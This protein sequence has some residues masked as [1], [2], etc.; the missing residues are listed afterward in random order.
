MLCN[1]VSKWL[2]TEVQHHM[3]TRFQEVN[4]KERVETERNPCVKE[5]GTSCWLLFLCASLPFGLT[6]WSFW[7]E[8][9][10]VPLCFLVFSVFFSLLIIHYLM[11]SSC[12]L[13]YNR[14]RKKDYSE[15][16]LFFC[17][18]LGVMLSDCVSYCVDYIDCNFVHKLLWLCVHVGVGFRHGDQL[19]VNVHDTGSQYNT[20]VCCSTGKTGFSFIFKKLFFFL[21]K[22]FI[23]V[24]TGSQRH[25]NIQ[26]KT[27]TS[28][29]KSR[30]KTWARVLY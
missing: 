14:S 29:I 8:S 9:S 30:N 10:F 3:T 25:R 22:I 27:K 18:S 12:L 1:H 28:N 7:I 11:F 17:S 2:G 19:C 4:F 13:S 21:F 26:Y 23:D 20:G 16:Y 5:V 15:S 6:S 24:N